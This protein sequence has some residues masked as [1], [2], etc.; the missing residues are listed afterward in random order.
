[1]RPTGL[2]RLAAA[3]FAALSSTYLVRADNPVSPGFPYGSTKVRGVN[4]GGW[5]VLEVSTLFTFITF[6]A[7][8]WFAQPWITPSLFERTGNPNIVDE[9]TFGQLQNRATA[10]SAL[11]NH[12]NTWIT[13]Q[14][15]ID[16]ANAG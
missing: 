15:F 14:D 6:D 16:I 13:E 3:A 5:L 9:W 7:H 11:T 10:Q 12:W 2:T 8:Q 1:M 4:L